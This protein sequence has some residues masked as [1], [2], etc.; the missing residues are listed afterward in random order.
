MEVGDEG[1]E[2]KDRRSMS[3]EDGASAINRTP[4][5]FGSPLSNNYAP[6]ACRSHLPSIRRSFTGLLVAVIYKNS[7]R[8]SK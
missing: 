4:C 8:C 7:R 1:D 2:Q 5:V 6:L 3:E